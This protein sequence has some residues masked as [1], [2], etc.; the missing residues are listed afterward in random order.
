MD[1]RQV[2]EVIDE[3]IF[4]MDNSKCDGLVGLLNYMEHVVIKDKKE[5]FKKRI[6]YICLAN[7]FQAAGEGLQD[8]T[9]LFFEEVLEL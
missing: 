5:L 3:A 9:M 1:E 6:N 7:S 4:S 2:F 8:E